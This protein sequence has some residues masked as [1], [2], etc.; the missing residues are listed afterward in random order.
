M[1]RTLLGVSVGWL[2]IS[3]VADG[4]PALL[5]PYQLASD[6][7]SDAATLG[8]ITLLALGVAAAI[9]PLAGHLADR[10]GRLPIAAAGTFIGIIGLGLL[11]QPGA[12]LAGT[13]LALAGVSVAQ[14]GQQALL[15]D[16]VPPAMRGR[17]GGLK[18]AFDVAGAFIGFVI[19]AALLGNGDPGAAVGALGMALV[20]SFGL[21]A[22]L[23]GRGGFRRGDSI[24]RP[25]LDAYRLPLGQHRDLVTVVAARFLFLLGIY[26]VGRF[27]LF[28]VAD[29]LGLLPEAAGEQAGTALALL[30]A[31]TVLASLP[32]GWLA[33]RFGR[34]PLMVA[35]GAL[36]AGGI[37]LLPFASS[38]ELVILF[39]SLMALGT[40]A[41]SSASWALLT[42]VAS[43]VES[44]RLLGI[45]HLGTAGAAAAAG[46]FGP[47]IDAAGYG[48]AFSLAALFA[49]GGGLVALRSAMPDG[50]PALIGSVEGV[51]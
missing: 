46:L 21:T 44:G 48:I 27:L 4:L 19:L 36:A 14:A 3:L 18:S 41:F 34:R 5:L 51:R 49:L 45:A 13:V 39:G 22:L 28:F 17:G 29:R 32:G 20:A 15:P 43:P 35:G 11:L 9:Q 25:L 10:V 6:G 42:D 38:L 2:G 12:A 7:A 33:D 1:T 23:L 24:R 8:L 47:V 31:I 30:A 40:A 16:L 50:A 26:A 37:G